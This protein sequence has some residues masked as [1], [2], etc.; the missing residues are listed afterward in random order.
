MAYVVFDSTISPGDERRYLDWLKNNNGF[1]LKVERSK[2]NVNGTKI[3]W[4]KCGHAAHVSGEKDNTLATNTGGQS[5]K[6][7]SNSIE[8]IYDYLFAHNN[9][10]RYDPYLLDP[11]LMHCKVCANDIFGLME[12]PNYTRNPNRSRRRVIQLD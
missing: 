10:S 3:Q 11:H 1:A 7:C 12:D 9:D 5:F 8:E 4:T 2:N 6:V